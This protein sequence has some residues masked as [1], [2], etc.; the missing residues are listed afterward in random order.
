MKSKGFKLIVVLASTLVVFSNAFCQSDSSAFTI[1]FAK[2]LANKKLYPQA[3]Y[4]LE[5]LKKE[6]KIVAQLDSISNFLGDYYY[7]Q[8][9][10]STANKNYFLINFDNKKIFNSSLLKVGLNFSNTK[11]YDSAYWAFNK[12]IDRDLDSTQASL[13]YFSLA[14]NALLKRD[15]HYYRTLKENKFLQNEVVLVHQNKNDLYYNQ[16]IRHKNKSPFLAGL[17][18]AILPGSGKFYAGKKGEAFGAFVPIASLAVLS[19]EAYKNGGI[20]SVPFIGFASLFSVF[21]ISNI[22]GSA[23]SV[24]F[25]NAEFNNKID[26]EI[27]IN[28]QFPINNLLR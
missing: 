19:I 12:I 13:K 27:L 6:K 25:K 24:K 21:Y 26:N 8:K 20:R 3:I 14:S 16:I 9:N 2:Y 23:L 18:S 10:Y 22:W 15:T 17:L 5:N 7:Y 11:K 1:G 4:V 28:M